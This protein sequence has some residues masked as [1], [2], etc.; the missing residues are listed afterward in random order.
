MRPRIPT[1]GEVVTGRGCQE[2]NRAALVCDRFST[3]VIVWVPLKP[4]LGVS[5][6]WRLLAEWPR[7]TPFSR[8][9]KPPIAFIC[10]L[11]KQVR[12]GLVLRDEGQSAISDA[13]GV[14]HET[15]ISTLQNKDLAEPFALARFLRPWRSRRFIQGAPYF[16]GC[17]SP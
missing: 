5:C 1:K 8:A 7:R 11:Q 12:I 4:H 17:K 6:I 10:E 9:E 3:S 15:L 16:G 13:T 14:A 2:P